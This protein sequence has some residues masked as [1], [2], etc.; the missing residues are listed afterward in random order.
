MK[1]PEEFVI[2]KFFEYSYQPRQNK[3][4]GTYQAG[5]PICREGKSLGKKRR[6]F[7]LPDK[8][9]IFCHNCGWSSKSYT[10]IREVSGKTDAEI[11]DEAR[12]YTDAI[13]ILPGDDKTEFVKIVTPSL[14]HDSINLFDPVQVN[15]YNSNP[16]VQLCL[17]VI[18]TRRL[19]TAINKPDALYVSLVDKFHKNRLVIPFKNEK[20]DI[21]FYQTR[22]ITISDLRTRPK[23]ISRINAEKILFNIDKISP[24]Y[25][26]VFIFE[27]PL[28]AF[29][30]KN[31]VAVA[32]I[33]EKG[34][35]SFTKRQQEQVDSVLKWHTRIWVLDSQWID[36]ASLTKTKALLQNGEK[37]FIWPEK[38]GRIF[39]DFNDIC[40]ACKINEIKHEFIE[41][42][43]F[44]G[45]EGVLKLTYIERNR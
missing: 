39:K 27:G 45:L 22:S 18:K 26:N 16:I 24:D 20:G 33:T 28:N 31:S 42:N 10:W 38:F 1:L 34:L 8:D 9:I 13:D 41:K 2:C 32:G 17:N 6:C 25:Q 14:P 35:F 3:Y 30:T 4:N 11:I 15:Y 43:T 12:E 21:E 29:F 37:V 5:C 44:E 19:D 23:Y 40:D 7:Y 36:N